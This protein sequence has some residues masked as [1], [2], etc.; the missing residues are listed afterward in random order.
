MT[1]T[2]E[3]DFIRGIGV[4]IKKVMLFHLRKH[5]AVKPTDDLGIGSSLDAVPARTLI[6]NFSASRTVR[7]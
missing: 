4:C 1:R 6:V 2:E 5:R 7:N 3:R